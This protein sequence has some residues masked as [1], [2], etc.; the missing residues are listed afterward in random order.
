MISGKKALFYERVVYPLYQIKN[1][2]TYGYKTINI[3]KHLNNTQWLSQD[4]LIS[5]QENKLRRL[6]KHVYY[7]VPYY[8][9]VM[10]K[11][12]LEPED[13]R[14]IKA[15]K[16]FPIL[17][18]KE[19][20]DNYHK[21][22]SNEINKRGAMKATTSGTTGVPLT[23]YRDMNTCVWTDAALLRGMSW[24]NYRLGEKIVSFSDLNWPS[25]L[26]KIRLK[27]I[28][29]YSFP[30]F[31]KKDE[32]V[33]YME[34]I[35]LLRP[36][37]LKGLASNL[38]RI[39]KICE[40][41]GINDIHIPIIFSTAEMLYDFQ[42]DFLGKHFRSNVFDYYG[43]NEVGSLAYEC[44]FKNKHISDEHVIVETTDS[45]G[46]NV[47][48]TLGEITI[49]DLDNYAMPFIRYKNGDIGI[50]ANCNCGCKRHLT[51]LQGIEGRSQDFLKTLDGNLI[52]SIFFPGHFRNIKGVEQ[53]QIIQTDIQNIT[54]KIV[55]NKF[56][57]VEELE[58]MIRMIREMIGNDVNINIEECS[59]IPLTGRGKRRLVISHL[60]TN[61]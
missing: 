3:L 10:D 20:K 50:L 49:T 44:E 13:I 36:F 52:P 22:I 60:P 43:C 42:R 38:Y 59:H 12:G 1:G 19:I 37:C 46:N 7:N 17:T 30:A 6:I 45:N 24:A 48:N 14:N 57:S 47:I 39:A 35:K 5:Y 15:L 16:Y 28:H 25:L 51:F 53:Y 29:A 4:E 8:H 33:S 32:L 41:N 31:A 55:K 56:F 18:K 23:F 26:G 21:I 58:E 61:F 34:K 54:L 2:L 27:L 40:E 11:L 9:D